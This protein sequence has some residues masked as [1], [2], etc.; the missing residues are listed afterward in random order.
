MPALILALSL[1][2]VLLLAGLT[3]AREREDGTFDMMLMTPANSMEILIGKAVIPTVIACL[4]AFLIFLVGVIWFELPF[5]GS[6]FALGVLIFGFALSFVGLGLAI[7]AVADTI[8]QAIVTV[9]FVMMPT[10]IF[11][12]L[13]TSVL[14]MPEWMQTLSI[15]NPLRSSITAL[16]MIYFE[17]CGLMET[18]E[19]FWPAALAG[20]ASMSLAAWLFR[21]KIQ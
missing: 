19:F 13:L 1:I 4:Q 11:S 16:R 9:I 20:A 5:A 6:A 14:A 21:H 18:I 3:V 17:G 12:G 7:S 15:L 8:Q 2:Q 10:I